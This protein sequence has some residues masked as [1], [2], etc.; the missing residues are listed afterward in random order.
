MRIY[1]SYSAGSSI[2]YCFWKYFFRS[3]GVWVTSEKIDES[4][5]IDKN[6]KP[7]LVILDKKNCMKYDAP[8]RNIV[9]CVKTKDAAGGARRDLVSVNPWK[10][11]CDSVVRQLFAGDENLASFRELIRIFGGE[12]DE[13]SGRLRKEGLWSAVWL[14]HE[15]AQ[16]AGNR[17]WDREISEKAEEALQAL[18]QAG[19]C[20]WYNVYMRQYCRY[21]QCGVKRSSMER[22]YEC[23]ELLKQCGSLAGSEWN[24]SLA[25]LAG[26]ISLLTS[27]ENKYAV[28]YLKEIC[29]YDP[30]PDILYEIGHVY[31]MAYG[32]YS[33]A[34]RYYQE[35]YKL[36]NNYYRSLY[37]L[38]VKLE[39]S[40]DWRGAISVYSRIRQI[41]QEVNPKHD[42][43]VRDFEY[44]YKSCR[45]MLW[46]SRKYMDDSGMEED[47]Q[48]WLTDMYYDPGRYV[49]FDKLFR[50]MFIRENREKKI[51]EMNDVLRGKMGVVCSH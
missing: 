19:K 27:T 8:S 7:H 47:L 11:M 29:E 38:A 9:Y 23:E 3:C 32:E 45:R 49:S 18:K 22:M 26:K 46:I 43:G 5:R 31:E 39:G 17:D 48:S 25:F 37:K 1:I 6:K 28:F 51:E 4:W 35:A 15:I 24:P 40:G 42:V 12:Y 34:L 50:K 41:I 44:E 20:T 21:L 2:E 13:T 10:N 14:F 33:K 36:D 16:N 30:Q